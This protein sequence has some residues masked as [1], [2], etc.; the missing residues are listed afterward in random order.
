M[1][2]RWLQCALGAGLL[3]F[4]CGRD[5]DFGGGDPAAGNGGEDP[6]GEAGSTHGG[7]AS[8]TAGDGG[9]GPT[10]GSGG[11]AAD[12]GA[13]PVTEGPSITTASLELQFNVPTR[14]QLS[15]KGGSGE[16]SWKLA[17]GATL[18]EG[19]ELA[20]DGSVSGRPVTAGEVDVDVIVEDEAARTDQA[21]VTLA[22][23]RSKR[24]L[25]YVADHETFGK[26]ELY[27][28][29]LTQPAK[30][31]KRVD[32][33]VAEDS[34]VLKLAF[35]PDGSRL[36]CVARNGS[37]NALFVVDPATAKAV[38]VSKSVDVYTSTWTTLA[39][40]PEGTLLA[41]SSPKMGAPD[42]HV[43][44]P[45]FDGS[46]EPRL[47]ANLGSSVPA[48]DVRWVSESRVA[49]ISNAKFYAISV[50]A[51]GNVGEPE[52]LLVP[53]LPASLPG[54][55]VIK[56][57][58]DRA[59]LFFYVGDFNSGDLYYA[60]FR[61][62][63]VSIT[64][65]G[66]VPSGSW[67][68]SP[69]GKWLLH[70]E[71]GMGF[72][73]SGPTVQAV[74]GAIAPFKKTGTG[75]AYWAIGE[76]TLFWTEYNT[77][78]LM[79]SSFGAAVSTEEHLLSPAA[80]IVARADDNQ[81]LLLLSTSNQLF[82]WSQQALP[83]V[84]ATGNTYSFA[85]YSGVFAYREGSAAPHALRVGRTLDA[86]ADGALWTP[87]PGGADVVEYAWSADGSTALFRAKQS[88]G[89]Q[90]YRVDV[91]SG[92]PAAQTV[93]ALRGCQAADKCPAVKTFVLQP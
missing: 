69:D 59:L 19:L 73:T 78:K 81:H 72:S 29:D 90:L 83:L 64:A 67:Q 79:F 93:H 56:T 41:F 48:L 23:V 53:N 8:N 61:Q 33:G 11:E 44:G 66:S 6:G 21:T 87:A 31:P 30:L 40:S 45:S 68:P 15:A 7:G 65:L 91:M 24:W 5:R 89:E 88:A 18:P 63:T 10:A 84:T 51:Q 14:K 57:A 20:S 17:P 46:A 74:D 39:W 85:P 62:E 34:D 22:V 43:V 12:A 4:A 86:G 47:L 32:L 77:A 80:T 42:Y 82:L 9:A 36:A 49:V 3:V 16:L 35:S 26:D 13:P 50:P 92:K 1:N 2:S 27:I 55:P 75:E 54:P 71:F 38:N 60:D 37:K 52:E 58:D 76:P 28:A 25:A 70:R